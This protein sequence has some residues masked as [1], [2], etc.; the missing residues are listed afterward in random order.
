MH[1]H[2][3]GCCRTRHTEPLAVA[4]GCSLHSCCPCLNLANL[5]GKMMFSSRWEE[6]ASPSSASHTP[7]I[8]HPPLFMTL[9]SQREVLDPSLSP[10]LLLIPVHLIFRK[11]ASLFLRQNHIAR[12]SQWPPC[13][14]CHR[15]LFKYENR[16]VPRAISRTPPGETVTPTTRQ[17]LRAKNKKGQSFMDWCLECTGRG[18][19]P[20]P[21]ISLPGSHILEFDAYG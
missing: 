12:G 18:Q 15:M 16:S 7:R 13:H 21:A 19:G 2:T 6:A 17:Q 14:H 3:C 4:P 9:R 11:F 10:S 5:L 8:V 20:A 1:T